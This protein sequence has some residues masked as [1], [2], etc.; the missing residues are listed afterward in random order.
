MFWRSLTAKDC[1]KSCDAN[2]WNVICHS[3][4]LLM[5]HKCI[6]QLLSILWNT[7][8]IHWFLWTENKPNV[9]GISHESVICFLIKETTYQR[10]SEKVSKI[11]P[12]P[13]TPR[14]WNSSTFHVST[15]YS[16]HPTMFLQAVCS[17]S[18]SA[19]CAIL[20]KAQKLNSRYIINNRLY[21]YSLLNLSFDGTNTL[22]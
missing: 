14:T 3:F 4:N 6:L 9:T 22:V 5:S 17:K 21:L 13:P 2:V 10:Y 20:Q 11:Y 7:I 8:F 1:A 19:L 16:E 18:S 12:T 15:L